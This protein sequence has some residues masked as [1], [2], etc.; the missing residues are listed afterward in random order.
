MLDVLFW[1]EGLSCSLDAFIEAKG[2]IYCNFFYERMLFSTVKIVQ[3]LVIKFLEISIRI[4]INCWNRIH[5][6]NNADPCHWIMVNFA[7]VRIIINIINGQHH[8]V[9]LYF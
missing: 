9:G 7:L 1:L 6:E 4:D 2:S 8:V 5:N 3:F